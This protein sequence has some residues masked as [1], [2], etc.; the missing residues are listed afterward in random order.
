MDRFLDRLRCFFRGHVAGVIHVQ[1]FYLTLRRCARCHVG[2]MEHI[3]HEGCLT[4]SDKA[5]EHHCRELR[6]MNALVREY[7]RKE[8]T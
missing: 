7:A 6:E 8:T 4:L 1:G 2:L 3:R 5:F